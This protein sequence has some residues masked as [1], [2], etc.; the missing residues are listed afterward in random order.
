MTPQYSEHKLTKTLCVV[1]EQSQQAFIRPASRSCSV[2]A[3][4]TP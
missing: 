4:A 3:E 2:Q 1:L